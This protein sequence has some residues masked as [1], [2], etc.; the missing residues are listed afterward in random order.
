MY[1]IHVSDVRT[2]KSCRQKWEW[3]SPL[4]R[5]LEPN[6][7]PIYFIVGRA[8]HFALAQFYE[9]GEE[10]VYVYD[11][12]IADVRK[13]EEPFWVLPEI[14]ETYESNFTLG[15]G[16]LVNYMDWVHSLYGPDDEW[17]IIATEQPYETPLYNLLGNKSNKVFLVGRF[18]QVIES[19]IDGTLWLREFKTS[20]RSPDAD[21]LDFDDQVTSYCV[22][23][24]SEILTR[25][26]W[27]TYDNLTIGEEVLGY[28]CDKDCLEWTAVEDV[29]VFR[30]QPVVDYWDKSFSFTCT[31][32]HKWVQR[33]PKWSTFK[34]KVLLEPI[35]LG[36]QQTY[37]VMSSLLD[38]STNDITEDEAAYL[39]WLLGDGT[40]ANY[41]GRGLRASIA[42]KKYVEEIQTLLDRLGGDSVYSRIWHGQDGTTN[43]NLRIPFLRKLFSKAGLDLYLGGWEGFVLGMSASTRAAFCNAA[44]LAE[45]GAHKS[46]YQNPGIKHD[47]FKLAFFLSGFFPTRS[48]RSNPDSECEYFTVSEGRRWTRVVKMEDR[49]MHED[50]WCPQTTLRTWV[51]RQ[52]GQ[53][54]ITGN[55]WGVQQVLGRPVAGIQYRFL[56]KRVPEEPALIYNGKQLSKAINSKLHTTRALYL[57]AIE[58]Y[59]FKIADYVD[60]LQDLEG[61]GWYEYFIDIPVTR[62]QD[63]LNIAAQNLWRVALEMLR[64]D[65]FVYPSPTW[66]GCKFC[67]FRE[68]CYAKQA[69]APYEPILAELYH[70]RVEE[71]APDVEYSD[72]GD[73]IGKG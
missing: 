62:S 23:L 44:M 9:N 35:R 72:G 46:F 64:K 27:K 60:V 30:N 70:P 15:R 13:V 40:Y 34:N 67:H 2:F 39:A 17:K 42:Q 69:G 56:L 31:K 47:L 16:M 51:M 38:S 8:I 45:G 68:P 55:S 1:G 36:L 25:S 50:V 71:V 59:K 3:S 66:G 63:Q 73:S 5:Y 21:W 65:T 58:K 49:D 18:D 52:D 33:R 24:R 26:G 28:N 19:K 29:R 7:T 48:K 4:R 53:I 54:V 61:R 43:W 57:A 11:R 22:P 20:S 32:D 6:I 37:V 41:G 10:P 12:F 14:R